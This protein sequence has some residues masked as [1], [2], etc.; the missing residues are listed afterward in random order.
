ML[1]ERGVVSQLQRR[2]TAEGEGETQQ[3]VER[4]LLLR[5]QLGVRVGCKGWGW[6]RG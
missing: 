6:V 4:E 3:P 2:V 1:V 5:L